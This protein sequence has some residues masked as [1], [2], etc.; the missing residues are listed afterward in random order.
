MKK[1][2]SALIFFSPGLITTLLVNELA[3]YVRFNPVLGGPLRGPFLGEEG[4]KIIPPP[5]ITL[6]RIMIETRN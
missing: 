5:S 6:V 1:S 2:W 4:V 3:H